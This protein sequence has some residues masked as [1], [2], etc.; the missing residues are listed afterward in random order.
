MSRLGILGFDVSKL[1]S[2]LYIPNDFDIIALS[3]DSQGVW[4]KVRSPKLKECLGDIV[5]VINIK[6]KISA[7]VVTCLGI[8]YVEDEDKGDEIN[9]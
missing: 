3:T 1:K 2:L 6:R 8:E 9:K 5:P 4:V 7:G